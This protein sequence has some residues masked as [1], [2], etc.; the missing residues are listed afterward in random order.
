V[1]QLSEALPAPHR[2]RWLIL[3]IPAT[4][5]AAVIYVLHRELGALHVGDVLSHF[6]AIPAHN[7][8]LATVLTI[9]SYWLLSFYDLLALRYLGRTVGYARVLMTSFVSYALGHNLG[10]SA[11]TG[12]AVRIEGSP[13]A[14]ANIWTSAHC[15]ELSVDLMRFGRDTVRGAMDFLLIELMLWGKQQGY[16]W[17]NLGMA[18]LS[19]LHAGRLAPA[20]HRLGSFLYRHG[21]YF[22]NFEGLR[23]YK[24]KFQPL[25]EPR[26][27][28]S[29]GGIALP[30]ILADISVLIAGGVKELISK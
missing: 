30:R 28:V 10:L 18:P 15:E 11:F 16:Q 29:P 2:H 22:Y 6:R 13:V 8:A 4:I 9:T 5:F 26:Y 20:W 24:S 17:F 21:E 7:L 27:L 25:W 19:G 3:A 23:R 12:A 14:F 1:D